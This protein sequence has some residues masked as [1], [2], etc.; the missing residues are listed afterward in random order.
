META[1]KK[2]DTTA[3]KFDEFDVYQTMTETWISK[4]AFG[5]LTV[6]EPDQHVSF[7]TDIGV[8]QIC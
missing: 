7:P 5:F 4:L 8:S 3:A 6:L 1:L 2:Y